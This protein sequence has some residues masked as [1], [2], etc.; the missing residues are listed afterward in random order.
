MIL[1]P[2]GKVARYLFG[3]SFAPRDLRLS[4]VEASA[5]RIGSPV[6]QILLL[7][8][9]YDARSGKYTPIMDAVRLGGILTVAGLLGF[10]GFSWY[11][12][13]RKARRAVSLKT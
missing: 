1:T 9:H 4:L 7:C 2:K 3:V 11:Y 8:Y 5:N 6:D 13:R 10:M 12:N